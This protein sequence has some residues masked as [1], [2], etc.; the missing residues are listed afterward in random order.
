MFEEV[1]ENDGFKSLYEALK[2][3]AELPDETFTE[4]SSQAMME[5][6]SFDKYE[7]REQMVKDFITGFTNDEIPRDRAHELVDAFREEVKK[8]VEEFGLVNPLKRKVIEHVYDDLANLMD[9]AAAL[10]AV[11]AD[12]AISVKLDDNA[13]LPVY[14][15][16]I[17]AGADLAANKE[18][19]LP[20]HSLGNAVG[21]G[22][23]MDI[24]DGWQMEIR[25]R[26]GLSAKTGL[27]I[28]N[29]PGTI[30]A[31]YK[32]EIKVLLDNFSDEPYCVHQGD[33]IA[34]MVFSP[35][36]RFSCN[37]VDDIGT[38]ERGTGGFG[39]TGK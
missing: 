31:G 11:H 21:T 22:I 2:N 4:E 7:I 32:G 15:H 5:M 23:Y 36:Y 20:P 12:K 27:R 34:Q 1:F 18:V 33:R 37:V 38:S 24:P 16:D 26:S 3:L 39:S 17:D 6:L 30:D 13:V 35:V 10:Y 29:A 14:A 8:Y 28:S 25:P 9:D 19:I